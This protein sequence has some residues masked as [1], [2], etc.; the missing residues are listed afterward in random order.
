[1]GFFNTLTAETECPACR[2]QAMFEIQFKYGHTRQLRYSLGQ[3][4][5]WGA[6]NIGKPGCRKVLASG[7]A[8]PCPHCG[9][10]HLDFDLFIE[11]DV[12][13]DVKPVAKVR[14]DPSRTGYR[15]IEP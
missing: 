14:P 12:I 9:E 3:P 5:E 1:M 13:V 6:N 8:G 11:R 4:L 7:I 2:Q 10:E 15:V